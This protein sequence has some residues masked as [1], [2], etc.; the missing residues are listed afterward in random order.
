MTNIL[1]KTTIPF[2]ENDWHAGRFS[3]LCD[4]VRSLGFAVVACDRSADA[5]GDD[6]DLVRLADSSFAQLWLFALEVDGGLTAADCAGI[7]AF[8]LRGGGVLLTRDHQDMG[9]S[10]LGLGDLGAAHHFHSHNPEPDPERLCCDDVVTTAISWPNDYNWDPRRGC[11]SFV[12]EPPGD[13][14]LK[15]PRAAADIRAYVGHLAHWL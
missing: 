14:M 3:L 10:L 13:G 4:H 2:A 12:S 7:D 5:A 6:V 11:P 1:L 15:D 9:A 8:R